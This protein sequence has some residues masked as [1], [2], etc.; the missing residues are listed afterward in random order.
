MQTF[1]NACGA[2]GNLSKSDLLCV[3]RERTQNVHDTVQ[4]RSRSRVASDKC[5][6]RHMKNECPVASTWKRRFLVGWDC[7]GCSWW[8]LGFSKR[9]RL[10]L[11]GHTFQGR[12]FIAHNLCGRDENGV[13]WWRRSVTKGQKVARVL[14]A[15]DANSKSVSGRVVLA[16]RGEVQP[17]LVEKP[18][19]LGYSE[20]VVERKL[21]LGVAVLNS[22]TRAFVGCA[23]QWE[24]PRMGWQRRREEGNEGDPRGWSSGQEN[25][26]PFT[27]S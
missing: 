26:A 25:K 7:S 12:K 15:S 10:R 1:C 4:E 9:I 2:I 14:Q 5:P 6:I 20:W 16:W 22:P 17:A 3:R 8:G 18:P 21:A 19:R 11:E 24:W 13:L 23:P 27:G